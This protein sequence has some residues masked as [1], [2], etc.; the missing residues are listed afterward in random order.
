M[1]DYSASYW[2]SCTPIRTRRHPVSATLDTVLTSTAVSRRVVVCKDRDRH[3]VMGWWLCWIG[4]A[5]VP[6][7]S[8]R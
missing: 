1:A 4:Q 8:Q 6:G 5:V 7:A 3:L 2:A